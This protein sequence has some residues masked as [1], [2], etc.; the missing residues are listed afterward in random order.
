MELYPLLYFAT[1]AE[2][3]S[4]TRAAERL[5]ISAPSNVSILRSELVEAKLTNQESIAE[6]AAPEALL[7]FITAPNKK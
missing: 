2:T 3:G 7:S 6:E 5:S 1:V 4:L